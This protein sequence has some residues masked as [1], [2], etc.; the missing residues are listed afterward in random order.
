MIPEEKVGERSR[1]E[2]RDI[3]IQPNVKSLQRHCEAVKPF[4]KTK[5]LDK[6]TNEKCFSPEEKTI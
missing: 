4:K 3:R 2:A 1:C 6:W 5:L